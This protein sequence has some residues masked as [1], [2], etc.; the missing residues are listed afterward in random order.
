MYP[1]GYYRIIKFIWTET[2]SY[3]NVCPESKY[4]LVLHAGVFWIMTL[5]SLASGTSISK[6]H[7]AYITI[8][9]LQITQ[10]I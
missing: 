10:K 4:M 7:V 5:C 8:H 3:Q 1:V 2:Q 6:E 9:R